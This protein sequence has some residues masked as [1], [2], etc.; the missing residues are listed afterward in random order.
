MTDSILPDAPELLQQAVDVVALEFGAAPLAGAAAQFL[1][2]ALRRDGIAEA[3]AAA[4]I[5]AAIGIHEDRAPR[6][7][8]TDELAVEDGVVD[9]QPRREDS[10]QCIG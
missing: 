2:N 5:D 6:N 1:E 3:H 4:L 8:R 10:F 9:L 7:V